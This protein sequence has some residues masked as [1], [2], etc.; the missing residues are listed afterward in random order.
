MD[1]FLDLFNTP[2]ALYYLAGGAFILAGLYLLSRKLKPKGAKN[3]EAAASDSTAK[4]LAAPLEKKAAAKAAKEAKEAKKKAEKEAFR[5]KKRKGER[6]EPPPLEAEQSMEAL[7]D[8]APDSG[9][10]PLADLATLQAAPLIDTE[11]APPPPD[12]LDSDQNFEIAPSKPGTFRAVELKAANNDVSPSLKAPPLGPS[13]TPLDSAMPPAAE[14]VLAQAMSQEPP[15]VHSV[16]PNQVHPSAG[17]RIG[18][19][20]T[21][22]PTQVSPQLAPQVAAQVSPQG[23][24]QAADQVTPQAAPQAAAQV[25]PQVA[26]QVASNVAPQLVADFVPSSAPHDEVSVEVYN[27]P[28]EANASNASNGANQSTFDS[29]L[30]EALVESVEE[31]AASLA[32]QAPSAQEMPSPPAPV[33]PK[34]LQPQPPQLAASPAPAPDL[35]Q[36]PTS[37][38]PPTPLAAHDLKELSPTTP[39]SALNTKRLLVGET[40]LIA[41]IAIEQTQLPKSS[42]S[43]P[44]PG[45]KP[46]APTIQ[47]LEV[48]YAKNAFMNPREIVYYKLLRSAFNHHLIF[49]K[50][51]SIAAVAPNSR[52][53]EHLKI[54][55]YVLTNTSLSFVVCD[56]R[57]NIVAV[58]E[59]VDESRTLSNKEKARDFIL[60]KAGCNVVRFYAG[61]PPPDS[62]DLRHLILDSEF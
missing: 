52:N 5:A 7:P 29:E 48:N 32:V 27:S 12:F 40:E 26:P 22:L 47:E 31:L 54:A 57:L 14:P 61:D 1:F 38:G 13:V 28:L 10:E 4:A 17:V 36:A 51:A 58:V 45:V 42:K 62:A 55:E 41:P 46:A 2:G 15:L 24:P 3:L 30:P 49:P 21:R 50:V 11:A 19:G 25:P 35:V 8:F 18:A 44:A 56:V 43:S 59:V 37:S 33:S 53:L 39:P 34:R 60:K 16:P 20:A 9:P 6:I 23:A